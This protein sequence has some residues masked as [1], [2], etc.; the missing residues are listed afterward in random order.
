MIRQHSKWWQVVMCCIAQPKIVVSGDS[1]LQHSNKLIL[2]S[3]QNYKITFT[4]L[5][6]PKWPN[7]K[8]VLLCIWFFG[9]IIKNADML[10]HSRNCTKTKLDWQVPDVI[11]H[12]NIPFFDWKKTQ[13]DETIRRS[14]EWE[15]KEEAHFKDHKCLNF[16]SVA[17]LQFHCTKNLTQWVEIY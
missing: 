16:R 10:Q 2:H 17:E 14:E 12:M 13:K 15:E 4:L 11:F 6:K 7:C 9:D 1:N 3:I 5:N 8:G